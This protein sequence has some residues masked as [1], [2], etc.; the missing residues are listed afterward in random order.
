M[1]KGKSST[2]ELK[3]FAKAASCDAI[4]KAVQSNVPYAVQEG[5]KIVKFYP[6]GR[7][8]VVGQVDKAFVRISK[9]TYKMA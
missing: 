1:P 5:R 7:K 3:R 8:E 9:K 4:R 6:D 2:E